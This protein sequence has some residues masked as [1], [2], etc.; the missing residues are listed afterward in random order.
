MI[1]VV[2]ID[3]RICA[4]SIDELIVHEIVLK[5]DQGELKEEVSSARGPQ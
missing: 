2:L 5:V 4:L 1:S 3:L